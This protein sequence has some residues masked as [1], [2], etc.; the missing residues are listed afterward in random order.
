V[1]EGRK[2]SRT[3]VS[4][5][6]ASKDTVLSSGIDDVDGRVGLEGRCITMEE[7]WLQWEAEAACP[8][9]LLSV[10]TSN[11]GLAPKSRVMRSLVACSQQTSIF[12]T[13]RLR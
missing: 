3:H 8:S 5:V 12:S 1:N 11:Y 4:R 6:N 2:Q 9:L 10:A 13:Q 7:G